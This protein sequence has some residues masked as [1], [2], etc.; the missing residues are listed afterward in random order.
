[1][2]G[3]TCLRYTYHDAFSVLRV[4][5]THLAIDSK[6]SLVMSKYK[7]VFTLVTVI[8]KD[9]RS[10]E[11]LS[12]TLFSITINVVSHL[13]IQVTSR[14]SSCRTSSEFWFRCAQVSWA[15]ESGRMSPEP[16][17]HEPSATEQREEQLSTV[18]CDPPRE[19]CRDTSI[20]VHSEAVHVPYSGSQMSKMLQHELFYYWLLMA[21]FPSPWQPHQLHANVFVSVSSQTHVWILGSALG[22]CADAERGSEEVRL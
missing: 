5:D 15:P 18:T 11:P 1:M 3:D 2:Y 6:S 20:H 14:R 17:H 16:H 22:V 10:W 12:V 19:R 13:D 9:S 7:V 8:L 21:E 4:Y